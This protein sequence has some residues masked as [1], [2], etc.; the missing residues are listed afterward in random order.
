MN[1]QDYQKSVINS[2]TWL[3]TQV[4]VHNR[5]NL[6]DINVHSENFY[7]DLLNLAFGY[8]L[9]NINI[10]DA[11]AAA[12]DLGDEGNKF[13]IQVT[14]TSAL[15]KTRHTVTKFIEKGLYE[16][17][18]H[19]VILN[20]TAKTA[21]TA[22][23]V[24]DSTYSLNTKDDIWDIGDLAVMIN[25]LELSKIKEISNFLNK[26][27]YVKPIESLPRNVETI[28]RLIELISDEEHPA[29]GEGFLDEPFPEEKINKRFADHSDFLKQEFLTL[30]QDYGAVLDSVEQESD[31][32][33]VKIRR[34][35][36]H[37]R[38]YSDKVLTECGG[39]SK[40]ALEKLIDN[41]IGMLAENG[42][43]ADT[44]AAQFYIV[45][46]LIRCNVFPNKEVENG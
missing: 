13:A 42:F 17:Y 22:E 37:L 18:D 24:G 4:T 31:I 43:E 9:V 19:L 5:L 20:I 28:L 29:A 8:S 21:H 44:G 12:I 3:S 26:Q 45:K 25:D 35:S 40:N 30:Y 32:G 2:L 14:S 36:Q 33:Q 11:N 23:T 1:R 16:K 15:A 39:D 46:H 10:I 41:F 6:T 38:V 7:R 34:V 27:L